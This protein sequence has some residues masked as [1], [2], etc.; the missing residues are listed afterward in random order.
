MGLLVWIVIGAVAGFA[1]CALSSR[2]MPHRLAPAVLIMVWLGV[3]ALAR[4][5]EAAPMQAQAFIISCALLGAVAGGLGWLIFARQLWA[6][7]A[8]AVAAMLVIAAAPF[9]VPILACVAARI[10]A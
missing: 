4:W 8:S 1:I 5:G 7:I 9:I 2:R 3:L 10:C 6:M